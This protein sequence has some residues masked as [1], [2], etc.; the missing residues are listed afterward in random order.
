MR[1]RVNGK[2]TSRYYS[3]A[4]VGTLVAQIIGRESLKLD[5][6]APPKVRRG[7]RISLPCEPFDKGEYIGIEGG[8]IESDDVL[9]GHD[10]R[11]Y[12]IASGTTRR[13]GL[14]PVDE[15][16]ISTRAQ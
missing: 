4:E 10:G 16:S 15:I 12:C 8:F 1:L 11:W 14:V 5:D 6:N 2:M 9:R 7:Q 13:L 3:I